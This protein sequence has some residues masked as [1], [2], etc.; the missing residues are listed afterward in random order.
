MP[1]N[2]KL[3]GGRNTFPLYSSHTWAN[4]FKDHLF[5]WPCLVACDL[6]LKCLPTERI[7]EIPIEKEKIPAEKIKPFCAFHGYWQLS[8]IQ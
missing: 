4:A 2:I 7:K 1:F 8:K 6:L 3:Y 5:G